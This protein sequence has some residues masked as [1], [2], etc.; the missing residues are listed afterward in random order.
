MSHTEQ[1][2]V[3]ATE[4]SSQWIRTAFLCHAD[5]HYSNDVCTVEVMMH[6]AYLNELL[7]RASTLYYYFFPS[8]PLQKYISRKQR[9]VWLEKKC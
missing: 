5:T 7:L 3:V 9:G 6:L 4:L 8:L 1:N 2:H